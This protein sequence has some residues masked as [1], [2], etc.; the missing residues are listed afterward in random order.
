MSEEEVWCGFVF[1]ENLANNEL[2]TNLALPQVYR[3]IA[4]VNFES[5]SSLRVLQGHQL[6]VE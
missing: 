2:M 1:W 5:V 3:A 4:Q 6:H